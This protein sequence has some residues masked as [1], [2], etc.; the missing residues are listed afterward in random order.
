MQVTTLS[1]AEELERYA[2]FGHEVYRDNPHWVPPDAHHLTEL[3]A[4]RGGFGPRLQVQPFWAEESGRVLATVTAVVDEA[5]N[6]RWDEQTGHLLFFEAL[7]GQDGAVE[8]LVAAACDWLAVLGCRAARLSFLAGW[9]M[10]LTVDAYD[11]VPTV[12]HTYNPPYY[13][14]YVKNCGFVT[15]RGVV[16]YQVR[17]TPELAERYRVMVGRAA[18]GGVTIRPWDFDRLEE[19]NQTFTDVANESFRSHWGFSPLPATVMSGLTT[20]LKDLLVAD[21]T[22]FAEADGQTIGAV[23]SLPDLNQA[24][25]PMRGRSIEENFPEFQQR[26]QAIDHGVLLIIGVREGYRGRGVNLALAASSYLGMIERGYKAASYTV[27]LDD[28]WPSRRT[29]EKLGARVVRN[30]NIY[31]RELAR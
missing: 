31:R 17:F 11:A 26:L 7:P 25:H 24:L 22:A 9:Q 21:F 29:A 30:F 5:Y 27:V 18:S 20:E 8:A 6:R 12:F 23:Y 14:S 15:E 2:G 19:E 1:T 3:L 10:P 16:Q 13:H 28:N 4:G